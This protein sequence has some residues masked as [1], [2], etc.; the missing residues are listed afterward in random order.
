MLSLLR[1]TFGSFHA[2]I[3]WLVKYAFFSFK[4][5]E[6]RKQKSDSVNVV[7]S[8]RTLSTFN[9]F[10]E[11]SYSLGSIKNGTR[12]IFISDRYMK[13]YSHEFITQ[14]SS[15]LYRSFY[16]Y[17]NYLA[18]KFME[19]SISLIRCKMISFIDVSELKINTLTSANLSNDHVLSSLGRYYKSVDSIE[20]LG[21]KKGFDQAAFR[22]SNNTNISC[23][24]FKAIKDV[25]KKFSVNDILFSHGYY[26]TWGM[27]RDGCQ[28]DKI[29]YTC[30]CQDGFID[31]GVIFTNFSISAQRDDEGRFEEYYKKLSDENFNIIKSL[32]EK[33]VTLRS[34]RLDKDFWWD[35]KDKEDSTSLSYLKWVKTQKAEGRIV[36]GIFPNLIWDNA[37]AFK[38]SNVIYHNI[39]EWLEDTVEI[40]K[41]FSNLSFVVRGHPVEMTQHAS[42]DSAVQL[43][44]EMLVN[45]DDSV[46]KRF[47]MIE[48]PAVNSYSL[49]NIINAVY[50]F[51]GTFGLEMMY[52]KKNVIFAS[53]SI[54]GKRCNVRI[55]ETRNELISMLTNPNNIEFYIGNQDESKRRIVAY[56]YFC[57]FL[58]SKPIVGVNKSIRYSGRISINEMTVYEETVL[59][60][61]RRV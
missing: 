23:E 18:W 40:A 3:I 6:A 27:I 10:I 39:Y 42:Q 54:M 44:K 2:I 37:T 41:N 49:S 57:F 26:S 20:I 22:F 31:E 9:L 60:K 11:L 50:L 7:V 25:D 46:S 47:L 55:P 38:T 28:R 58:H 4:S 5:S 21:K 61:N 15:N 30:Y 1:N 51:N 24:I 43:M 13:M 34:S 8:I 32:V 52:Y 12:V 33:K 19:L 56:Y 35:S 45:V 16:F 48:D 36:I 29:P 17:F 53:N 59:N 14:N